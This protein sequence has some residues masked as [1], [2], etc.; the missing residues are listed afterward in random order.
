MIKK[1]ITYKEAITEIENIL[2][3][4]DKEELDVDELCEKVKDVSALIKVC[5]DKLHTTEADVKNILDS[6]QV[7]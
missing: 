5:K 4:I 2:A 6:I 1:K 7:E 3:H